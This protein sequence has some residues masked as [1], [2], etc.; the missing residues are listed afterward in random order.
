M[1]QVETDQDGHAF[2]CWKLSVYRERLAAKELTTIKWDVCCQE[3]YSVLPR[4]A[5]A[6]LGVE[7]V[8]GKASQGKRDAHSIPQ[9]AWHLDLC[10]CVRH[11]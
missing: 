3:K 7:G 5:P 2:A 10:G 9:C 6:W 8:S 1:L 11:P 4:P